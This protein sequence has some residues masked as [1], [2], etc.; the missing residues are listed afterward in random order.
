MPSNFSQFQHIIEFLYWYKTSVLFQVHLALLLLL[1]IL[2]LVVYCQEV[3]LWKEIYSQ[4]H[5]SKQYTTPVSAAQ[6]ID[7]SRETT[8]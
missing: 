4:P 2:V 7:S 1:G 5:S 8:E 3:A 6:F